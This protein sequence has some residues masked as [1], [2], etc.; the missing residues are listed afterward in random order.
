MADGPLR[1]GR[2]QPA[3]AEGLAR[4]ADAVAGSP[5]AARAAEAAVRRGR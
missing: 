3:Q 2:P 4:L 1:R 5:L